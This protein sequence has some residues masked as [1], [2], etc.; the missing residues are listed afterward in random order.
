MTDEKIVPLQEPGQADPLHKDPLRIQE[1]ERKDGG[2]G[3]GKGNQREEE[4]HGIYEQDVREPGTMKT[5]FNLLVI[6]AMSSFAGFG[7]FLWMVTIMHLPVMFAIWYSQLLPGL[8][9]FAI[10][11]GYKRGL[12]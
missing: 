2:R 11:V 8:V 10:Y 1:Q 6:L 4:Q 12:Q 9:T 5:L 3:D 7:F